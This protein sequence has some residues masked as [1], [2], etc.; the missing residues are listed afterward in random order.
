MGLTTVAV[1]APVVFEQVPVPVPASSA[2]VS[3]FIFKAFVMAT[4]MEA[5]LA[6]MMGTTVTPAAPGVS[7]T[8]A[9]AFGKGRAR[10]ANKEQKYRDQNHQT[11]FHFYAS[12]VVLKLH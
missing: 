2:V 5:V 11:V 1:M 7:G 6:P 4:M 9:S 3:A 12:V 10:A 8:P